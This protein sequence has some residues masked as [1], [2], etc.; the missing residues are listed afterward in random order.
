M[1][2]W[3]TC[4]DYSTVALAPLKTIANPKLGPPVIPAHLPDTSQ[5]Q[6]RQQ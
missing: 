5:Q 4:T 3:L 1:N 2:E 6:L